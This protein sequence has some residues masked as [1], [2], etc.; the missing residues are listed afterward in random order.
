MQKTLSIFGLI[1]ALIATV[2]AVTKFSNL[3]VTPIIIAFS[4]GLAML[5]LSKKTRIQTKS[6]QYIFLL[7]IIALSLTIY[8]GIFN[9]SEIAPLEHVI[10]E[11]ENNSE[12]SEVN[13]KAI[14]SNDL[15]NKV[16][17]REIGEGL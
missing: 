10:D 17:D 7:V 8:K 11:N 1:S 14:N 13:S 6:I 15:K 9:T 3:A 2:L 4:C 12:A 5:F 16:D